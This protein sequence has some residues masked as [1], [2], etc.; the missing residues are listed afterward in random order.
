MFERPHHQRIA[1]LLSQLDGQ[2]LE[3]A[4]CFFGGGTAITLALGEY[5]ESV[6]IDFLCASTDGYRA[7]RL[8]VFGGRLGPLAIA[9]LTLLRDLRADQYGIRTF[10]EVDGMPVKFEIVREARIALAGALD[11]ALGVPVL[12]REDLFAEKL[13]A[14]ADRANDRATFSRDAIDLGMMV[15]QWGPVPEGAWAK[16]RQAYGQTIDA[17][18]SM[19]VQRLDDPEWLDTCA[20]AM[21]LSPQT[22]QRL[23]SGLHSLVP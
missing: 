14:N 20:K 7:L 23:L 22:A 8:A 16:A 10:I 13:L 9:P 5:Q 4:E 15:S 6:D 18:L 17:A 19:A 2:F 21:H 3:R 1:K 12:T 11:P